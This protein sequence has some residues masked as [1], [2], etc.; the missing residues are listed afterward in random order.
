MSDDIQQEPETDSTQSQFL[1]CRVLCIQCLR[2]RTSKSCR[3]LQRTALQRFS[4][5]RNGC[6][7]G[8]PHSEKGTRETQAHRNS[9]FTRT[10]LDQRNVCRLD[11]W[12]RKTMQQTTSRS[13]WM[14]HERSRSDDTSLETR[15]TES[16]RTALLV[17]QGRKCPQIQKLTE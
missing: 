6:S 14:D 12:I 5:S 11:A 1:R 17:E 7:F 3:T 13:F 4:S 15:T 8:T 2:K 9:V 16:L 10:T